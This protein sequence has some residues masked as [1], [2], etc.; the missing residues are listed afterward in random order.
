MPKTFIYTIERD[1]EEPIKR[2]TLWKD[3]VVNRQTI[4][5]S[6]LDLAHVK[7]FDGYKFVPAISGPILD[8]APDLH[9]S[10]MHGIT[11]IDED[12]EEGWEQ[13]DKL[14]R[15]RS[16]NLPPVVHRRRGDR[17]RTDVRD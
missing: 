8:D 2:A 14:L 11:V 4:N 16:L 13:L 1:Y 6:Q 3:S 12:G 15:C 17:P 9:V 7:E 5:E 10:Y